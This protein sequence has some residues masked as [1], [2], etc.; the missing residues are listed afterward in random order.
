MTEREEFIEFFKKF[1]IQYTEF[2]EDSSI[3]VGQTVF[4]FNKEGRYTELEWD[5]MLIIEKRGEK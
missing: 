2:P 4:Y 5:D 1:G 3:G